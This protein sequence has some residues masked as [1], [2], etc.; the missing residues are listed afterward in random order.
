MTDL[1][2]A[3]GRVDRIFLRE[4]EVM[5]EIGAFG[6]ER[7]RSQRLRLSIA[8][9]VAPVQAGDD[10]DRI[11][12]Y[13][14]LVEAV[15]ATLAED[16]LNLLET[17]AERIAARILAEPRALRVAVS[18]GKC[19]LGP[20]VMGVEIR[21]DRAEAAAPPDE[22]ACL[23]VPRVAL[24]PAGVADLAARVTDLAA[25]GAPLLLVPGLPDGLRPAATDPRAQRRIDLLALE[26]AAWVLAAA[27]PRCLVVSSRTEL[28]WALRRGRPV[29]WAPGKMALDA[30]DAPP[31]ADPAALAAWIALRLGA[32]GV[33]HVPVA[34][35]AEPCPGPAAG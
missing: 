27:D 34:A 8:V 28:D 19:D 13:D 35:P 33:V 21:R 12:S 32:G 1:L 7:G 23:P 31:G 2:A 10:V 4:H 17:L 29:I 5:A 15:S 24:V 20:F 11:L 26:Q 14:R 18:V 16:R 6:P 3:A 30:P 9:D 25:G 22:A